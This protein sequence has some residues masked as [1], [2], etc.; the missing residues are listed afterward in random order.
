[1]QPARLRHAFLSADA[2]R[3]CFE[4]PTHAM[5]SRG[6]ACSFAMPTWHRLYHIWDSP[7]TSRLLRHSPLAS[8][9][10][11][12][13]LISRADSPCVKSV[14]RDHNFTSRY[15]PQAL[16]MWFKMHRPFG[17]FTIL[18]ILYTITSA[19]PGI[20][21]QADSL[22][23]VSYLPISCPCSSVDRFESPTKAAP[24]V[25][26]LTL[27]NSMSLAKEQYWLEII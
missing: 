17:I 15:T 19:V 7:L 25:L 14:L 26:L 10:H 22:T 27:Q 12:S 4:A 24:L 2:E 9:P 20:G 6:M 11:K 5:V 13:T 18:Q 21:I 16:N 23:P 3:D 1:M 8:R